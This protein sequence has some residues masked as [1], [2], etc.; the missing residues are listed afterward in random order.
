[1]AESPLYMRSDTPLD[2]D[3]NTQLAAAASSGNGQPGTS[4]IIENKSINA[5]GLGTDGVRIQN[6]TAYS[7]LQNCNIMNA[8]TSFA[9]NKN[10]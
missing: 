10:N 3:G 4:Y 5:N 1:M 7:I 6:T 8:D 2:I 9:R